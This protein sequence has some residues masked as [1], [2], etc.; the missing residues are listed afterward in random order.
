M[1]K[2]KRLDPIARR[3][4]ETHLQWQARLAAQRDQEASKRQDRV[5]PEAARHGIYETGYTEI[6]GQRVEVVINRG[7]ATITRWLNAKPCSVLGDRERAAI[8]YTKRLWNILDYR[9]PRVVVVDGNPEGWAE[10]EALAEL[11]KI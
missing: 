7:G 3:P 4:H 11:S 5:T 2:R 1:S 9:G 6:D 10:H 8:L